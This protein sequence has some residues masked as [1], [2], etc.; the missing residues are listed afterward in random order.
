M[1][2]HSALPLFPAIFKAHVEGAKRERT[3]SLITGFRNYLHYHIKA[4][5]SYLHSR[6]RKRCVALLQV[7]N[8]AVPDK[9]TSKTSKKLASGK[10]FIRR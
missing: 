8:R 10:T 2:I 4:S 3:V 5:K 6:M 1:C 7:L 9:D